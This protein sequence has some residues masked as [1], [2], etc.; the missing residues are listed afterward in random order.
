VSKGTN[1]RK[2]GPHKR[3]RKLDAERMARP[4]EADGEQLEAGELLGR[5]WK[6]A[7]ASDGSGD[8]LSRS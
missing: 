8:R 1:R 7:R 3:L 5:L 2:I 6:Q 4:R